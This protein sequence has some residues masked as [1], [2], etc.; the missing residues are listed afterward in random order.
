MRTSIAFLFVVIISITFYSCEKEEITPSPI[1]QSGPSIT[2]TGSGSG[3]GSGSGTTYGDV[4]FWQNGTYN[5]H[6]DVTIS[7]VTNTITHYYTNGISTCSD[8]GTAQFTLPV[9]TYSFYAEEQSTG[10]WWSGNITIYANGCTKW[11]LY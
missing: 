4:A 8:L 5:W 2:P 6:I 1:H 7:G 3:S 11:Q 10:Y 9:G